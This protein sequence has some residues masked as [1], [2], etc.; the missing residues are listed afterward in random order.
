[1]LSMSPPPNSAINATDEYDDTIL[2][3]IGFLLD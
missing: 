2:E 3:D 1:V